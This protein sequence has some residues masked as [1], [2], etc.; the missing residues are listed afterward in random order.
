M[1]KGFFG[2]ENFDYG[3]FGGKEN[4]QVFFFGWLDLSR[5]FLGYSRQSKDLW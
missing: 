3:I 5:D 1:I 4:W 2:F